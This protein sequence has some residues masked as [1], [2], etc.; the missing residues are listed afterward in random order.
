MH[1]IHVVT[2]LS[3]HTVLSAATAL[4]TPAFSANSHIQID[5]RF[6]ACTVDSLA[7]SDEGTSPVTYPRNRR[8]RPVNATGNAL[9]RPQRRR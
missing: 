8:N 7:T 4:L 1:H 2:A 5:H 6:E 3:L 9:E